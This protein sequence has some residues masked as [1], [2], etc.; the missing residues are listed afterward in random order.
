[1]TSQE[2][3]A[4]F[5][6]RP[7]PEGGFFRETYRSTAVV[8]ASALPGV[9]SGNRA[10]STA[11][12]FLLPEGTR[13]RLH[14]LRSDEIWHFYLGGPLRMVFLREPGGVRW[15]SVI[16]GH[17]IGSG[18]H[19]QYLVRANTWFG[20]AP[21]PGVPY[22]LVGCTVAPGF[23]FEDFELGERGELIGQFPAEAELI[24]EWTS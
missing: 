14:R 16:L 20:A 24:R 18:Q 9:L 10:L 21:L 6:L 15:D 17:D 1:M 13:S 12:L 8:S 23:D 19:L 3:I 4:R 7:H 11:I 22:S 2:L 5:E